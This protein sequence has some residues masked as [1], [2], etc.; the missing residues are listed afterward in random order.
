[1]SDEVARDNL[2][3]VFEALD[4]V[5]GG[6][7][8]GRLPAWERIYRLAAERDGYKIALG[9]LAPK[10]VP[11]VTVDVSGTGKAAEAIRE[12]IERMEQSPESSRVVVGSD[13]DALR[14]GAH[15]PQRRGQ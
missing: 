7:G 6:A 15:H 11:R 2:F 3:R 8:P 4:A 9:V 13:D 14:V 1:M 5:D 10:S 12:A